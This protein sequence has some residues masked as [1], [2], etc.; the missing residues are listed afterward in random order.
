MAKSKSKTKFDLKQMMLAKGE[1]VAMGVAGFFLLLLL[2]W[3]INKGT[4]AADPTKTANELT[5]KATQVQRNIVDGTPSDADLEATK[6]PAWAD[7]TK[8]KLFVELKRDQFPTTDPQFDPTAKPDTKKEN[9]NVYPIGDYQMDLVRAPMRGYD[10]I[11]G[12]DGESL[13]AVLFDKNISEQDR[14]KAKGLLDKFKR[15]GTDSRHRPAGPARPPAGPPMGGDG[16]FGGGGFGQPPGGGSG[17]GPPGGGSGLGPPGGGMPGMPRPPGMGG[18]SSLGNPYGGQGAGFDTS[19]KRVAIEYVPISQLDKAIG[20]KKVPAMTVIPLRMVM[21]HAE[22][23]YKQ[24]IEEIRRALRL[25]DAAE[26]MRWGPIYTGYDVQRKVSKVMPNGKLEVETDWADYKYLDEYR[27]LIYSR[28]LGDNFEDGYLA[29]FIRYEMGLALPLPQLVSEGDLGKYPPIRLKNIT[30]AIRKLQEAS[31]PKVDPSKLLDR[32]K[33]NSTGSDLFRPLTDH[34]TDANLFFGEGMGPPGLG[35]KGGLT[36]PT[37]GGGTSGSSLFKPGGGIDPNNPNNPN[38]DMHSEIENLLLRFVDVN[39]EPGK[40]YE[41]RIRLRM[42]N[43]NFGLQ[44][45]VANPKYATVKEIPSPWRELPNKITIPTE[46]FLYAADVAAYRDKIKDE[47]GK[48]R[49]LLDRLQVKENQAVIE[50]CKWTEEVRTGDGGRREPIGAWVVAD[51]PVGRGE[52]IGHKH[53]VKLPLWSSENKMYVLR[54]VPEKVIPPKPNLKDPPQPRGWL[55][56]FTTQSV[57]VDFEGGKVVTKVPGKQPVT[58]DVGTELLIV[59]A[60][61]KLVVKNSMYDEKD[62]N[63]TAIIGGWEKWVKEV[64]KRKTS[65][66]EETS[67]FAPKGGGPGIP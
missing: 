53:Y 19:G 32:L 21:I 58:E 56:D 7:P 34:D 26:A 36:P 45:E 18:G 40:T 23:P 12:G 60:D 54:E 67:P 15:R 20:D 35:G 57:L 55:V 16:R 31:K 24:Q 42:A 22:I 13:I 50:M 62:E 52:Y 14:E 1:Y 28:K 63:R 38:R 9:P 59:R 8:L 47:Y 51:M 27:S 48:E 65:G 49:A 37:A 44:R 4:S 29:Y 39:V 17:L 5:S 30:E 25:K 3:G 46:S 43:P 33:G 61:G 10:I 11:D 66:T 6:L 64:E 2:F 41:Y